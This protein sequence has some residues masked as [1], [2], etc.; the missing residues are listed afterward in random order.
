MAINAIIYFI[1][2]MLALHLWQGY[3]K[4][5][6][7]FDLLSGLRPRHVLQGLGLL[8]ATLASLFV[9]AYLAATVFP[10]LKW[11][12]LQALAGQMTSPVAV[13][14]SKQVTVPGFVIFGMY[15]MFFFA[16]PMLVVAEEKMFRSGA[17]RRS[18]TGNVLLAIAFGLSHSVLGLPIF[19]AIAL[20]P[21]GMILTRIYL[22]S[23]STAVDSVQAPR[24]A[25]LDA[26]RAHLMNNAIALS[27]FL[28]SFSISKI[29]AVQS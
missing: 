27:I 15:L 11:S 12:W 20:I 28:V 26:S 3:K 24:A 5:G 29:M 19:C 2:Y 4:R 14:A 23:A 9:M 25:L 21:A 13:G 7:V 16:M 8:S 10:L 17:E 22:K 6:E 18:L 1:V